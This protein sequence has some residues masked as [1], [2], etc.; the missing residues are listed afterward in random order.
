MVYEYVFLKK[1]NNLG[2]NFPEKLLETIPKTI[3]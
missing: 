2:E 3:A 1:M